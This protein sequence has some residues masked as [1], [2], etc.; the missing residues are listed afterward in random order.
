MEIFLLMLVFVVW[1]RWIYVSRKFN[2]YNK[3]LQT[4]EREAIKNPMPYKDSQ[5]KGEVQIEEV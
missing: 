1:L 4:L 2:E 3:R 5:E